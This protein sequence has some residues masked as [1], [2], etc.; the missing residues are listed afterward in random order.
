[1]F[2]DD[3]QYVDFFTKFDASFDINL[4]VYVVVEIHLMMVQL[5]LFLKILVFLFP[6]FL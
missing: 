6:F 4:L 2:R 3:N 1:M 5:K